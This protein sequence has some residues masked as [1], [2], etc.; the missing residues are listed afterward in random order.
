M[1]SLLDDELPFGARTFVPLELESLV[2]LTCFVAEPFGSFMIAPLGSVS[3]EDARTFVPL[4]LAEI[5]TI[6]S[7]RKSS[8][9]EIMLASIKLPKS[10][11]KV[12]AGTICPGTLEE[13]ALPCV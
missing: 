9:D 8:R 12:S 4:S 1:A 3:L 10:V 11:S 13:L 5:G 7:S 6:A 2:N